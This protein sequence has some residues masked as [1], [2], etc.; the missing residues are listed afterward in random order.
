MDMNGFDSFVAEA[1]E[2]LPLSSLLSFSV[3]PAASPAEL[4][5]ADAYC[6]N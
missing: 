4:S 6:C 2:T 5:L 1:S 3:S